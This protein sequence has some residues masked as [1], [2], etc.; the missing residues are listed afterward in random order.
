MVQK[1]IVVNEPK[2]NGIIYKLKND[3]LNIF[4]SFTKLKYFF[5]ILFIF[6]KSLS[7]L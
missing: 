1:I 5:S 6:L 2:I 3:Y 7:F 4:Q